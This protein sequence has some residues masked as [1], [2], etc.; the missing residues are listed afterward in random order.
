MYVN[1]HFFDRLNRRLTAGL[2]LI[3]TRTIP[4]VGFDR[5]YVYMATNSSVDLRLVLYDGY[6]VIYETLDI[7]CQLL[8]SNHPINLQVIRSN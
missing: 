5:R 4:I 6:T 3:H 2:N 7:W 1:G 8:F